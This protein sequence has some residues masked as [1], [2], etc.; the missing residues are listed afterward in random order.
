M[1][2][3]VKDVTAPCTLYQEKRGKTPVLRILEQASTIPLLKPIYL[4]TLDWY[5]EQQRDL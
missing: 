3:K 5:S 4:E 2:I 1:A